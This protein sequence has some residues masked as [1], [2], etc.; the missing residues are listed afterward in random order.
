MAELGGADLSKSFISAQEPRLM[1]LVEPDSGFIGSVGKSGFGRS[2]PLRHSAGLRHSD[3]VWT[4]ASHP[5]PSG[6]QAIDAA[7]DPEE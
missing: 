3:F 1:T 6:W 4:S 2:T 7:L 5:V